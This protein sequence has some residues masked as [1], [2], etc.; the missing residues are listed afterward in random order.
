MIAGRVAAPW[1]SKIVSSCGKRDGEI[2]RNR[3][4]K[5]VKKLVFGAKP[6]A[7]DSM[8]ARFWAILSAAFI[9]VL[10]AAAIFSG[11]GG[12]LL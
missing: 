1:R 10:T 11:N 5:R 9:F 4:Q 7:C 6:N 12:G 3:G 2:G 8:G